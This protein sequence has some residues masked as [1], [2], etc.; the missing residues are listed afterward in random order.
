MGLEPTASRATTW[1]S[2]RLSYSRRTLKHYALTAQR[3]EHPA[4]NHLLRT[5][6]EVYPD[7]GFTVKVLACAYRPYA[8]GG[9]SLQHRGY[10]ATKALYSPLPI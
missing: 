9:S 1:H 2:N 6:E 7:K 3:S 10:A 4:S 5:L 8:P